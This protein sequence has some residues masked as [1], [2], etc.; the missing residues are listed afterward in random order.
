MMRRASFWQPSGDEFSAAARTGLPPHLGSIHGLQSRGSGAVLRLSHEC[1]EPGEG[2]R[3]PG[4][5]TASW[6]APKSTRRQNM[7]PAAAHRRP[8]AECGHPG[9]CV[10]SGPIPLLHH[11]GLE[12]GRAS[13][14]LRPERRASE[15]RD[16]G[17]SR[18][19]DWLL[20]GLTADQRQLTKHG[21]A[22]HAWD[23]NNHSTIAS[24]SRCSRDR[25]ERC[26]P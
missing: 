19:P 4:N 2:A 10:A 1:E 6:D 14:I 18:R 13:N 7:P 23:P 22:K 12:T 3:G 24:R 5:L 16:P 25:A 17:Q 20:H 26:L 9:M 8:A 15:D 11:R 21:R